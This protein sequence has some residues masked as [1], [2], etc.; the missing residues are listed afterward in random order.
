MDEQREKVAD[1]CHKQWTGWMRYLFAACDGLHDDGSFTIP[2]WAVD[3]WSRQMR[4]EYRF[5][6][7]E[8][9]ESDRQEADK[10]LEIII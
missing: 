2:K 4:T 6:T 9:K 5:L 8:E 10:F 3:R 7:E 1:L